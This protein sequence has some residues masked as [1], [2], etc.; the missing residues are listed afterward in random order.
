MADLMI[1]VQIK[2]GSEKGRIVLVVV[3]GIA[4][5]AGIA[6]KKAAEVFD[7]PVGAVVEK[8]NQVPNMQ[9][10]VGSFVV[11]IGATFLSF[12]ISLKIMNKKEF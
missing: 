5:A 1:P 7:L 2:Y 10:L 8:L 12:M 6:L 11:A 4:M 9:I 3:A